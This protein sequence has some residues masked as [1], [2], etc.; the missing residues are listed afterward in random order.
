MKRHWNM[1]APVAC[2]LVL[3]AL[4]GA[5][6]AQNTS[7]GDEAAI[8]E[9]GVA[10]F[11]AYNAGDAKGVARFY[12]DDAVLYPPMKP[13]V[14]GRAAIDTFFVKDVEESKAG[15]VTLIV[16]TPTDVGASG[17]LGYEGGL[18]TIRDKTGATI[19]KSKFVTVYAKRDG[20]WLIIRD[21]WNSDGHMEA[22]KHK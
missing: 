5:T 21:C 16:P 13:A 14:H 19:G 10:W 9:V 6:Y 4:H 12:A 20:K 17:N 7:A 8:R 3:L 11:K 1:T 2:G 15:G 18:I 22:P